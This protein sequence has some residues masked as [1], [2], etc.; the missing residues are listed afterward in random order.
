[1]HNHIDTLNQRLDMLQNLVPDAKITLAHGQM[2]ERILEKIMHDFYH[3]KYHVLLCTT[4]IENG[5]D[6]P[7]VNTLIIDRADHLGLSQMHQLRG[8]VGRSNQQA[9]AYL[10]VPDEKAMTSDAKKRIDAIA[11][12]DSLGA[13]FNLATH[14][15]EIRGA[16]ELLGEAQT[17]QMHTLGY[18]LYTELLEKTIQK[19]RT[20][21]MTSVDKIDLAQHCE[22]TLHCSTLIPEHTIGDV[23]ARLNAYKEISQ[24]KN[25]AELD[26]LYISFVDRFGLLPES[27]K[28]LF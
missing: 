22:L 15:L 3:R 12:M 19:I 21:R 26:A 18:Q 10:I 1:M 28:R 8:R 2:H 23:H 6:I 20:G 4:I 11:A 17:G 27:M 25:E 9:Y 7:T 5:I 13:G 14:D 24:C 16:G